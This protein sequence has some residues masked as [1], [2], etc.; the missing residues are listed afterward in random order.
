MAKAK[1]GVNVGHSL[2]LTPVSPARDRRDAPR[3]NA[4]PN[5]E[6]TARQNAKIPSADI[7][8][9]RVLRERQSLTV[10]GARRL[11]APVVL[12]PQVHPLVP[13]LLRHEFRV[14]ISGTIGFRPFDCAFRD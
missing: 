7:D 11:P 2:T 9:P 10:P 3:M 12:L 1:T 6:A 13:S 4:N 5:N 14:A 8:L